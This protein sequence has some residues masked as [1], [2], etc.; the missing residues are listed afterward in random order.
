MW[1]GG[2][3]I[4]NG[5]REIYIFSYFF[6]LHGGGGI[7]NR[8]KIKG[9]RNG[10]RMGNNKWER[11]VKVEK[12]RKERMKWKIGGGELLVRRG[13]GGFKGGGG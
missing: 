2:G 4:S 10:W 12:G 7:G 13:A 8:K 6:F 1:G 3:A 11:R 9:R 5:S